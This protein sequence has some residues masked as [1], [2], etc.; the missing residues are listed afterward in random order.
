M[1]FGDI[2]E[3]IEKREGFEDQNESGKQ[4]HEVI[5]ELAQNVDVDTS[6]GKLTALATRDSPSRL[7][8]GTRRDCGAARN[9]AVGR[10][11]RGSPLDSGPFGT[12]TAR[13]APHRF[14]CLRRRL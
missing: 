10:G 5:D 6:S 4:D 13:H 14:R 9:Q 11:C 12:G 7:A 3:Q 2:A 1:I 8:G